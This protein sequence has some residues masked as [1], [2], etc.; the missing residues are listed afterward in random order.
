MLMLAPWREKFELG[1]V[2]C[3]IFAK[4]HWM[5]SFE[6]QGQQGQGTLSQ[7]QLPKFLHIGC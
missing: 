4:M 7:K 2:A 1:A 6:V 5:W 3:G